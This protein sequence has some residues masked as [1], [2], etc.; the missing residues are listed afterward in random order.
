M[1]AIV[2]KKRCS[3][4]SGD[5][6]L[7]LQYH[8]REWG[9]PAHNDRKHFEVLVLSGAQAGL[10][11]S[12]V[13]KKREGY[14]RAF[15]KFDPEKVAR[16]SETQIRKLTSDPEIIR[17]RMKIEAAVR[18]AGALLKVQEEFGTFDSYCWRFVDGRPRINRWKA[19]RQIPAISPESEAFSKDRKR[20]G[21][22][23][24]GPTTIYA[25][26][27]AVG[28][29]NDHLVDCFRYREIPAGL[30]DCIFHD[31]E[32]CRDGIEREKRSPARVACSHRKKISR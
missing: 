6:P 12:L 5:D 21:F 2:I 24:V 23:F 26:M 11:W 8:D 19:T 9:V 22:T 10:N 4:V 28:M 17:N 32:N 14:R 3:W 13:L 18:N 20:R 1:C 25:Y 27:Q 7:L 30:K 29:V 15:N 31:Q 16:Y